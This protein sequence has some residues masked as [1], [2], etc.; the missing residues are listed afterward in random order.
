MVH[1]GGTQVHK[2][3]DIFKMVPACIASEACGAGEA[4]G[5]CVSSKA[6][7]SSGTYKAD[8]NVFT[9]AMLLS[10]HAYHSGLL[11]PKEQCM[12]AGRSTDL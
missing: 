2:A 10:K 9:Q 4:S 5:A 1:L 6:R 8:P 7:G 12:L 3:L 11:S